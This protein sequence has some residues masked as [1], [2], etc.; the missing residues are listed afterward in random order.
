MFTMCPKRFVKFRR[1]QECPSE[2]P[3]YLTASL[4]FGRS[5]S[6]ELGTHTDRAGDEVRRTVELRGDEGVIVRLEE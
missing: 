6:V 2:G 4:A 3:Q 1:S 5:G